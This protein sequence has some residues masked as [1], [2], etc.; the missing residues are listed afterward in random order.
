MTIDDTNNY[1]NGAVAATQATSTLNFRA[2][3]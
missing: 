3:V 1:A 2:K